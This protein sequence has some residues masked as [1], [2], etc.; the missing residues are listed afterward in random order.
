MLHLVLNEVLKLDFELANLNIVSPFVIITDLCENMYDYVIE[1]NTIM[2]YNKT[3][4]IK[5]L[6]GI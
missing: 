6:M 2:T 3:K 4:F 1:N 5:I